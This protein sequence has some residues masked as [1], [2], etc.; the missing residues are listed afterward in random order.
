MKK[1]HILVPSVILTVVL[2]LLGWLAEKGWPDMPSWPPI[3]FQIFFWVL[4][5]FTI[6]LAIYIYRYKIILLIPIITLRFEKRTKWRLMKH[7]P[8]L[9]IFP[10][11]QIV[12]ASPFRLGLNF[13]S[14]RFCYPSALPYDLKLENL[15]VRLIINGKPTKEQQM[16]EGGSSPEEPQ[17]IESITILSQNFNEKTDLHIFLTDEMKAMVSECVEQCKP[18]KILLSVI[19]YDKK[20]KKHDL[21]TREGICHIII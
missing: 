11:L 15:S 13:L 19:G 12:N 17:K 20:K 3:V 16:F 7:K 18:A 21:S 4:L 6:G 5:V 9:F 10:Y 2:G 1:K 8:D 14:V